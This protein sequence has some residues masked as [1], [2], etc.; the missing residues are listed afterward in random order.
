MNVFMWTVLLSLGWTTLLAMNISRLRFKERVGL[1]DGNKL[2][3]KKAIRAHIN[4]LEHSLPFCFIV[5][6]LTLQDGITPFVLLSLTIPFGIS[7]II[8]SASYYFSND[9]MR[10]SAA[11]I[12][13]TCELAALFIGMFELIN[14]GK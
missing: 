1:G 9:I 12:T 5:Y 7:R 13:Y 4:S 14:Y 3:L 8:H 2:S 6:V 11:G 10:Q